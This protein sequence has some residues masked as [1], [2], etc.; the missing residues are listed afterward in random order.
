[1]QVNHL[2]LVNMGWFGL[3]LLLLA[4]LLGLDQVISLLYLFLGP[5][6]HCPPFMNVV[7]A[8]SHTAPRRMCLDPHM[9]PIRRRLCMHRAHIS[10]KWIVVLSLAISNVLCHPC[11]S[12]KNKHSSQDHVIKYMCNVF[13]SR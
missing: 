12:H 13:W 11:I 5:S 6:F 3:E 7:L 1:M 9:R 2:M 8:T 10:R 4:T